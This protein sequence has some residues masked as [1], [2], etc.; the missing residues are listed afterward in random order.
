M[1]AGIPAIAG[2]GPKLSYASA[3]L[4]AEGRYVAGRDGG[5]VRRLRRAAGVGRPSGARR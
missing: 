5:Y 2:L 3:L 1:V 4:F